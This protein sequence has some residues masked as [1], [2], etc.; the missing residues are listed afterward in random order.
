MTTHNPDDSPEGRLR[1]LSPLH[2]VPSDGGARVVRL[3]GRPARARTAP[4]HDQKAYLADVAKLHAQAVAG[5]GLVRAAEKGQEVLDVVLSEIAREVAAIRYER[6]RLSP[7]HPNAGLLTGRIL[8]GLTRL[9]EVVLVRARLTTGKLDLHGPQVQ[10]A[11]ALFVTDVRRV[12]EESIPEPM[13]TAFITAFMARV[14]GW[15]SK[16][17]LDGP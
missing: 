3:P 9:A 4:G 17:E 1:Q 13:A 14:N 15:E 12:V 8:T 7:D 16:V 2:A 10:A 5:D 6:S 11:V